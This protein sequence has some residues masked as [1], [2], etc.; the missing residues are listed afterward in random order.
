MIKVVEHLTYK[1]KLR[2][3]GLFILEKKR[4]REVSSVCRTDQ[5]E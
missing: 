3:L 1:E 2:D 5:G 4:L